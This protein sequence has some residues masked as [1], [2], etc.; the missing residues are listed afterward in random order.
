MAFLKSVQRLHHLYEQEHWG[1]HQ[2]SFPS[3]LK[4]RSL[5][6]DKLCL[7]VS[8]TLNILTVDFKGLL[9]T[10]NH[11]LYQL[12]KWR[13]RLYIGCI[14]LFQ[15]LYFRDL[16]YAKY[17]GRGGGWSKCT[18]YTPAIFEYIPLSIYIFLYIYI[19]I[20]IYLR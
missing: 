1:V 9:C 2:V 17:Y 13:S 10:E 20:Y 14:A 12:S 6:Y 4:Q 7:S 18:I 16:Y 3:I 15:C 11:T 8:Q 5:Y 19:Y